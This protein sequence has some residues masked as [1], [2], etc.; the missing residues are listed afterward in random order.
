MYTIFGMS[1]T[2]R[3][4]ISISTITALLLYLLPTTLAKVS[5]NISNN[6]EG[7]KTSV[8]VNQNGEKKVFESNDGEVHYESPDGNT[9]VDISNKS[10]T[11]VNV[12]AD[13]GNVAVSAKDGKAKKNKK[14]RSKKKE[15]KRGKKLR[16]ETSTVKDMHFSLAEFLLG[17][18]PF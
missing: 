7:S 11:S 15:R 8:E 3:I 18:W 13:G 5:V 6:G 4:V 12:S 2:A 10:G 17:L 1:K 9:K 14:N 16:N